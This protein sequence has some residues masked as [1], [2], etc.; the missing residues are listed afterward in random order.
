M[1]E[2]YYRTA[3]A[4]ALAEAFEAE[5]TGDEAA[6]S[7]AAY[8]A[9]YNITPRSTQLAIRQTRDTAIREIVPMRWG[10]IGNKTSGPDPK[11]ETHNALSENLKHSDSVPDYLLFGLK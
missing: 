8:S 10:L 1:R 7:E 3:N 2:H 9:A 5:P 4:R 6:Y 11:L